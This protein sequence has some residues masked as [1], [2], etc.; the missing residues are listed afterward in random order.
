MKK[1]LIFTLISL[2][3]ISGCQQE[4][5]PILKENSLLSNI[6]VP[7]EISKENIVAIKT[8][9]FMY[10]ADSIITYID[11]NEQIGRF[12]DELYKVEVKK[13]EF[14]YYYGGAS[15]IS[16]KTKDGE[17]F[18]LISLWSVI[19]RFDHQDFLYEITNLNDLSDEFTRVYLGMD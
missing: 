1:L 17:W 6:E 5:K 10:E 8:E 7:C 12:I 11:D 4:R 18:H 16:V 3:L 13:E 19:I 15:E 2:L 9:R 14:M